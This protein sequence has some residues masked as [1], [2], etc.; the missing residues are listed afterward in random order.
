MNKKS[1]IAVGVA[2]AVIVGFLV[3]GVFNQK[4]KL[5]SEIAKLSEL[6]NAETI[7]TEEIS[8]MLDRTVTTG[9]YEILEKA[10]KQYLSDSFDLSMEMSDILNDKK[11]SNSLTIENYKEDGPDFI[12]TK[13]Y[14]K[15]T[16]EKLETCKSEYY[17]YFT[18]EKVMSYVKDK[19]LSDDMIKFYKENLVGDLDEE[20]N[21]TTVEDSLNSVIDMLKTSDKVLD[22]LIKSKKSWTI[23]GDQIIFD[24][25][26]L[27]KEYN[28][29]TAE[30]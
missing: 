28:K 13:E 8:K 21:N 6:A 25:N 22:L 29:L 17:E 16:I 14:I 12:N 7:D 9:D 10:V 5:E 11:I 2:V 26:T 18:E 27:L 24:N 23:E 4:G 3:Y 15:T 30:L 20:K 19:K 1:L